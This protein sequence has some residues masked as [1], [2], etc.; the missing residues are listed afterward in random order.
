[1]K[2]TGK[3]KQLILNMAASLL[4]TL[5]ALGISFLITPTVIA[6]LGAEAQGFLTMATNFVNYAAIAAMALNSMAGRFITVRI[7][8]GDD[9]GANRYFNSVMY[10]NLVIV[11]VLI[12]VFALIVL[13]LER[14]VNI[15]PNLVWDVK[16]LFSFM[17]A[18]FCVTIV[19][20]TFSTATF[21][22]NRLD[23]QALRSIESQLIKAVCLVLLFMLLPVR[24]CYM[25]A[26]ALLSN[27]YLF[28]SYIHYTRKLLP[29]IH[30][31]RKAFSMKTVAEILSAGIW[32]TVMRTGQVLTNQLDTLITNL[33]IGKTESGYIG[34]STTIVTSINMLYETVS[35][36]FTPSLTISFAKENKKELVEDLKSAM[37]L[38]GFFANIPLCYIVGFGMAF[39]TLWLPSEVGKIPIYY[40]LTILIMLGTLVG[41]A[42]SP[43]FNVYTIVNKLKWNSIV[44]LI[45]GVMNAVLVFILLQFPALAPYGIYFVAGLS[46][47]L[48]IIKNLT[49]TP[50]YAAHCLEL[51]KGVFYPTILRYMTVTAV[52]AAV[53]FGLGKVLPA[54]NWLQIIVSVI[55]C[56]I[57]GSILN[58]LF[59]FEKK[60]RDLFWN[61]VKRITKRGN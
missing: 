5:V 56:G 42:I 47:V 4:S 37:R 27:I 51:D 15:S 24:V 40:E 53:F 11:A 32:N 2:E 28:V 17:F 34:T 12:P 1:M 31:S 21:A 3:N 44:T 54:A 52:M 55:V 13:Y 45:M 57:V 46:S 59:L 9:E 38:T 25:G 41:G 26:A 10:A 36:V 19:S 61:T 39:Y 50:M 8:K 16:L 18:N 49:F 33:W 14:L 48:G 7:A 22:A 20:T 35:A 23:L 58:Y 6:K 43:L 60:E 29:G 30:I